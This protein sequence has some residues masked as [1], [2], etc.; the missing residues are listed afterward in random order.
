ML[1]CVILFC[2][3]LAL[4]VLVS[5][6]ENVEGLSSNQ[7]TEGGVP[8]VVQRVHN[9]AC[10]SR[11]TSWIPGPT[12]WVEDPVLLQLRCGSQL[13]FRLGSCPGTSISCG[14]GQ[15]RKKKKKMRNPATWGGEQ[16]P[17]TPEFWPHRG[18]CSRFAQRRA[19]PAELH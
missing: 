3:F 5:P 13:C 4:R 12:Q 2:S 6:R 1:F 9:P 8:T 18:P 17:Q 14:D 19:V 10:L 11:G 16:C 7:K 15:K